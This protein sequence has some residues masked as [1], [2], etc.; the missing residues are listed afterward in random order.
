MIVSVCPVRLLHRQ[1]ISCEPSRLLY[2]GLYLEMAVAAQTRS[3]QFR[4]S[5]TQS[6]TQRQGARGMRCRWCV[7][8]VLCALGWSNSNL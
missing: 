5:Q 4:E 2:Q 6:Q 1:R 3:R 7:C 8:R